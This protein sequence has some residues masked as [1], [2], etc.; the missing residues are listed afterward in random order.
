MKFFLK[1]LCRD[2]YRKGLKVKIADTCFYSE[3][4]A[5]SLY[6]NGDEGITQLELSSEASTQILKVLT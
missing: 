2:K 1:S 3:G 6:V 5:E 4:K